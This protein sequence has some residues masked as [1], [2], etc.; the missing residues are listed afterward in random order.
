M[1][2]GRSRKL[3]YLI[4]QLILVAA[5]LGGVVFKFISGDRTGP[6][7]ILPDNATVLS[8][9][10]T[11]QQLLYGVTAKD[12][13]SGDVSDSLRIESVTETAENIVDL[14]YVAK[15]KSNNV[16]KVSVTMMTDGTFV[17]G[18]TVGEKEPGENEA[19]DSQT[20]PEGSGQA[21][22]AESL[23][24]LADASADAES[25]E[26]EPVEESTES[27][28]LVFD[29]EMSTEDTY[30]VEQFVDPSRDPSSFTETDME[31]LNERLRQANNIA[32]SR[33]PDGC[34]VLRLNRYALI[35]GSADEFSALPYVSYVRDD[36]DSSENMLAEISIQGTEDLDQTGIHTVSYYVTDSEGNRSNVAHMIVVVNG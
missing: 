29:S 33:M 15:D 22:S 10:V 27:V 17:Y 6:E 14:V 18:D 5:L 7:I 35:K 13:R 9:G 23:T 32:I 4:L 20:H 12:D 1:E 25:S 2:Q 30:A 36:A 8:G 24:A 26:L 11:E 31:T 34:P 3:F 28:V 21:S 19:P 16:S